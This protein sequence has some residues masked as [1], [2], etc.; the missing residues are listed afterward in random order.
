M[1]T[2]LFVA[3]NV[4][5]MCIQGLR[6]NKIIFTASRTFLSETSF[7]KKCRC[8]AVRNTV[9]TSTFD[10]VAL[11]LCEA[12]AVFPTITVAALVQMLTR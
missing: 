7:K 2:S 11:I 10:A 3:R 8:M 9:T 1:C 4:K 12:K 5:K 6:F